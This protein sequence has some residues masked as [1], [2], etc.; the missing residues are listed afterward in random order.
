M[1]EG[2]RREA[3]VAAAGEVPPR[4]VAVVAGLIVLTI[5]LVAAAVWGLLHLWDA[6]IGIG[7]NSPRDFEP[8][9][10]RLEAA[11]Q[12]SRSAYFAEKEARLNS[13]GWVDRQAGI[14]HIPIDTAMDMLAAR[15][16]APA[17]PARRGGRR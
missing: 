4:G 13:Y 3:R 14:A 10:P 16:A 12:E 9:A 15:A 17:A 11:T 1:A 6:P 2:K 8:A 5:V 7:P